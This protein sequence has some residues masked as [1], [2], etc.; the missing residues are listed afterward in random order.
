MADDDDP[1][2]PMFEAIARSQGPEVALRNCSQVF[3]EADALKLRHAYERKLGIISSLARSPTLRG[4]K[5]FVDWY[6]GPSE[7]DRFWPALK[8][9]LLERKKWPGATVESLDRES[10]NVMR[11]LPHV[12]GIVDTKGLVIGYVQSGKTANYSALI[13][14]AADVGYRLFIVLAG[15]HNSLRRQTQTRLQAELIDGDERVKTLWHTLTLPQEDFRAGGTNTDAFLSS[16]SHQRILLVV[17]K[18]AHVL[19]RLIKW[20]SAAQ[21]RLL[22][23]C[24]ALLI[25]DEADQAGLN[26][27]K[28]GQ[29]DDRTAINRLILNLKKAL[30]KSAY[31]G[32]TATPFANV[33][34]DPSGA[35]L[36]P[37]DFVVAL[38]KPPNYFGAE[39]FF[40]REPLENEDTEP[41]APPDMFRLVADDEV[42]RL[43]P[44][45]PAEAE[46]FEADVPTSLRTAVEYFILATAA[47]WARGHRMKHS[48]ML[49]HTSM[50]LP[51]H[52][53]LAT[54][55]SAEIE[56]IRQSLRDADMKAHLE[57][58]WTT[59]H[60]RVTRADLQPVPFSEVESLIGA[61][62]ARLRVVVDNSKSESRLIYKEEETLEEADEVVHIAVGGNTLSRGLTL[63][64][65]LV[66]YFVRSASAY[67]TLLQMGRWFG[68]RFGY[69]DLPRIWMTD[70]L[71]QA[72]R[73]LATVEEEIRTDVA[74]YED[75]GLTPLQFAVRIRTHPTLAV[76]SRL[77]M[78]AAT[79]VQI[80]YA[81]F[82]RQTTYFHHRDA[83][84]LEKNWNAGAALV[85]GLLEQGRTFEESGP[86]R[87]LRGVAVEEVLSFLDSYDCHDDHT[88]M[89]RELLRK[90]IEKQKGRGRLGKWTVAAV[91]LTNSNKAKAPLGG[92]DL[93][94]VS[95]SMLQP[96]G[97]GAD[98]GTITTQDNFS[99]D[100]P[101]E[102]RERP[103]PGTPRIQHTRPADVEPLL[104]LIP[105]DKDS[106]PK[107]APVSAAAD[108]GP[109][110]PT[111]KRLDAARH[112]LGIALAFPNVRAADRLA[113][114]YIQVQL[115]VSETYIDDDDDEASAIEDDG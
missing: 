27:G 21:P 3:G 79:P 71:R 105:I 50:N 95:R 23:M 12:G 68:Y 52:R 114:N 18:N 42:P 37:S 76:T 20:L 14:K 46:D 54:C 66:S 61:V 22:E 1:R 115:P 31:V 73:D 81:G 8:K 29:E 111:R 41:A 24:P 100:L 56:R 34:T 74:R 88:E 69:E 2:L 16:D 112:V 58:L 99:F 64:G 70:E 36:Y 80:D 94:P 97:D 59:E 51:V 25:D 33:L 30:P 98:V 48:S 35:D 89:R 7:D 62:L 92:I 57:E 67:D 113:E 47:R 4:E 32:Y 10:T 55:I 87:F 93:V 102:K 101:A 15:I 103:A 9:H 75:E 5:R 49:V 28:L 45:K 86:H 77:K 17:K 85:D 78:Q 40:G 60:A 26:T 6:S 11:L 82:T 96:R 39:L 19:R 63:E 38:S 44:T 65:L 72:F 53:K 107:K 84:W 110:K 106:E 108:G 43:R 109:A 90:Y 91:T 13:A 83:T 104:L